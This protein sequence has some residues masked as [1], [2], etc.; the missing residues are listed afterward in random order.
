M[1]VLS[2][3]GVKN[4]TFKISFRTTPHNV[5]NKNGLSDFHEILLGKNRCIVELK[6]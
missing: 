5:R 4:N 2:D 6:F 1:E 3:F